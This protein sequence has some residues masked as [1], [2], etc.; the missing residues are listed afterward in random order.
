MSERSDELRKIS[1]EVVSIINGSIS[2]TGAVFN[3]PFFD[4]KIS[5]IV[6]DECQFEKIDLQKVTFDKCEFRECK[7][8]CLTIQEGW[9]IECKLSTCK[10]IDT[11]L[12][13]KF[14]KSILITTQF[15]HCNAMDAVSS[16]EK[17]MKNE[18]SLLGLEKGPKSIRKHLSFF[19]VEFFMI[20]FN[21]VDL[22][23]SMFKGCKIDG[24]EFYNNTNLIGA[25]F[26]NVKEIFIVL[27]Q[28]K[29]RLM[30]PEYSLALNQ[31][32]VIFNE[33]TYFPTY[34]E[35][36]SL[37]KIADERR[38]IG[39]VNS[40][41]TIYSSCRNKNFDINIAGDYYYTYKALLGRTFKG[42]QKLKSLFFKSINGYGE[43]WHR[44]M[45][46]SLILIVVSAF[47]Y[48][49]GLQVNDTLVSDRYI[50]QYHIDFKSMGTINFIK[51]LKDF[52]SCLYFSIV[53]FTTVGYGNMQA[54][55]IISNIISS[56]QMLVG[57]L[58]MTITTGTLLRRIIR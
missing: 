7:F 27:F 43:K 28:C 6:F 35:A 53:T 17:V 51:F 30:L 41:D 18:G 2:H 37:A 23:Y 13:V 33:Q 21:D 50:I 11:T 12:E 38:L 25:R 45:V 16:Y 34:K 42:T 48:L 55:G 1:K 22:Q 8:D 15:I 58:L 46:W 56:V 31:Y 32:P 9:F 57:V 49:S 29:Q 36:K 40:Y 44:G 3:R 39:L 24:I 19:D 47:L 14:E 10:F 5:G 54:I 20:D 52:A 26:E 4:S